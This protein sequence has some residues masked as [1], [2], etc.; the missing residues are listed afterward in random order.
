MSIVTDILREIW[1]VLVASAPW[2]LIGCLGAGLLHALLPM[3][4]VARHLGGRGIG[5]VL[6]A[7]LIGIPLPLCSCSV[8]PVAAS[9]RRRGASSGSVTSF[10]ISTPEIGADSIAL[11][12][13]LLGPGLAIARPIAAFL[14]ALLAGVGVGALGARPAPTSSPEAGCC[15]SGCGCEKG[16]SPDAAPRGW[17][18][19]LGDAWRFGFFDLFDDLA[20]WL[21]VGFVIAG[22][23]SALVPEDAIAAWGGDTVW[24]PVVMLLA[25][26]PL[27]VCATS[28]TPIAA[29]LMLKGLSPGAALVFLLAGPATNAATMSWV[30]RD[31]G[32]KALAVY[33]ASIAIVALSMGYALDALDLPVRIAGAMATSGESLDLAGHFI[34]AALLLLILRPIV[35]RMLRRATPGRPIP[36]EVTTE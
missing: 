1:L 32:V 31:L 19:R 27:Y 5:S 34:A 12:Y 25:G 15:E 23:V 18:G 2:F 10:A 30:L 11:T 35:T 22:V 36:P 4:A 21:L 8:I 28:S 13:A 17:R 14:S 24:A 20:A 16:K 7:T 26:L 33:L 29:A 6:K 3:S 9:L